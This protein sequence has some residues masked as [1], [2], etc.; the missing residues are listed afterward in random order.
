MKIHW[1]WP[2]ARPEELHWAEATCSEGEELV[3]Q[4]VDREAAPPAGPWGQ[5]LRVERNLPDV[6][7]TA[8]GRAQWLASRAR[9]YT[10]RSRARSRS[11]DANAPDIAH[12]H[13]LNRFTDLRWGGSRPP[14]LVLSVH[15]VMPHVLRGPR[16]VE[17]QLLQRIYNSADALIVHHELLR[18][19]LQDEFDIDPERLHVIG[20][21]V[22]PVPEDLRSAKPPDGTPT[23]L[24]FGALRANKGTTVLCKAIEL[25][26]PELDVQFHFAGRGDLEVEQELSR[27]AATNSSTTAEIG[28]I[29]YER[30]AELFRNASIVVLPYTEFSSQS[31]VLHD[32]YGHGRPVIVTDVGALGDTVRE[33]GTGLVV[34]P[35][36]PVALSKALKQLLDAD[37]T[38]SEL[39][40]AT[41]RV[42]NERSPQ[43]LGGNLRSIYQSLC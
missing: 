7:R 5:H 36:S 30:K 33:D 11:W 40:E 4:V 34:A 15:D 17:K 1:Y 29:E 9:T 16:R 37:G 23:V 26:P 18:T 25:L 28:F 14:V 13:Y 35:S 27:F 8:A 41:T 12:I 24:F 39:S 21:Q 3:V 10:E 42:A 38:R 22:F 43:R 32:A 31:G 20:H 19:R 2:F 6:D